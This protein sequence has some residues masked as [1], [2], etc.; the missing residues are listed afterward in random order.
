[1]LRQNHINEEKNDVDYAQQNDINKPAEIERIRNALTCPVTYTLLTSPL[2]GRECGHVYSQQNKPAPQQRSLV[3]SHV[4]TYAG[5]EKCPVESCCESDKNKIFYLLQELLVKMKLTEHF[6]GLADDLLGNLYSY[7]ENFSEEKFAELIQSLHCPVFLDILID[8]VILV[9]CGHTFDRCGVEEKGGRCGLC[10]QNYRSQDIQEVPIILEVIHWLS[11]FKPEIFIEEYSSAFQPHKLEKILIKN[12]SRQI[13]FFVD[14]L[15]KYPSLLNDTNHCNFLTDQQATALTPVYSILMM[16]AR[17]PKGLRL[18]AEHSKLRDAITP[19]GLNAVIV[20]NSFYRGFSAL[21]FFMTSYQG[22]DIFFKDKKLRDK[23]EILN[24][25]KQNL[26]YTAPFATA[27][28]YYSGL[29]MIEIDSRLRN[30]ISSYLLNGSLSLVKDNKTV[31]FSVLSLLVNHSTGL[32]ILTNDNKLRDKITSKGLEYISNWAGIN[33]YPVGYTVLM[34]LCNSP[35]GRILLETDT[36]LRSKITMACMKILTKEGLSALFIYVYNNGN[37]PSNIFFDDPRL[38]DLVTEDVLI[39]RLQLS[40]IS[41]FFLLTYFSESI[42]FLE[43]YSSKVNL[44]M[45]TAKVKSSLSQNENDM[46]GY[47]PLI[48]LI[49]NNL[50]FSISKLSCVETIFTDA[51]N[52][53][54]TASC[55]KMISVL[56]AFTNNSVGINFL[57]NNKSYCHLISAD[58]LNYV[59]QER[60]SPL[61]FLLNNA[62]GCKLLNLS[63][64]LCNRISVDILEDFVLKAQKQDHFLIQQSLGLTLLRDSVIFRSKLTSKILACEIILSDGS[65]ISIARFLLNH[66]PDLILISIIENPELGLDLQ[67]ELSQEQILQLQKSNIYFPT[68]SY[69]LVSPDQVF[70]IY[71]IYTYLSDYKN[72]SN[73]FKQS[74]IMLKTIESNRL[75]HEFMVSHADF[76]KNSRTNK[77][78]QL[79]TRRGNEIKKINTFSHLYQNDYQSKLFRNPL[80]KMKTKIDA[81]IS[82]DEID[83]HAENHPSSRTNRVFRNLK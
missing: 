81:I 47:S 75:T 23:I 38:N 22:C 52:L 37:I 32:D 10:Q 79:L 66:H 8:P 73:L 18:L 74:S 72:D 1:M 3:Q 19:K 7:T 44:G 50:E 61:Y 60:D 4:T 36:N 53:I 69:P 6:T 49:K 9:S 76:K 48:N 2:I 13:Q 63:N 64:A 59:S 12:D 15:C 35:R 82:L 24:F 16:L 31:N 29:K 67:D 46:I 21:H 30:D 65:P 68:Q 33:S 58:A 70:L 71:F 77:I 41:V 5:F 28:F 80:S 40:N 51:L 34:S 56:L 27:C 57:F 55:S 14:I 26:P 83:L 17:D 25:T 45:L 39:A 43:K 78:Y 62:N 42:K 11:L 54:P 20:E